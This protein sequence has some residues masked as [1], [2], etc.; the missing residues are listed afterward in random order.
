MQPQSP[1]IEGLE[2]YEI[3][4]A[5]DQPGYLP[6]PVLRSASPHYAMLSRWV[7]TDEERQAIADGA[8][9]FLT[10]YTGGHQYPPTALEVGSKFT[11]PDAIRESM[12]LD[13][14]LNERLRA[15]FA[16]AD[17]A[18]APRGENEQE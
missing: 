12:E 15:M 1:V 4:L 6:L 10:I 8:D 9:I 18:A 14:E 13:R 11:N 2:P 17:R 16:I 5:K 7:F 3:I